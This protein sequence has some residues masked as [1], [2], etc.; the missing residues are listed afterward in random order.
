MEI[1][2]FYYWMFGVIML[3]GLVV[4]YSYLFS[5]KKEKPT[6]NFKDEKRIKAIDIL[7][8]DR[9]IYDLLRNKFRD[10][11]LLKLKKLTEDSYDLEARSIV[12]FLS[13]CESKQ[14]VFI[15]MDEEFYRWNWSSPLYDEFYD[16]LM[17][18]ADEVWREINKKD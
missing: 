4:L 16:A 13:E 2:P 5:K 8:E 15:M 9:P 10:L 3:T 11:N 6:Y 14:D 12:S 18:I 1:A 7:P 17:K